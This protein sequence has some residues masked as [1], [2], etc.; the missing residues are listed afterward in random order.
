M[1]ES[2]L[3]KTVR[4]DD[5][6]YNPKGA[7]FEVWTKGRHKYIVHHMDSKGI[8]PSASTEYYIDGDKISASLTDDEVI[9]AWLSHREAVAKFMSDIQVYKVIQDPYSDDEPV[10]KRVYGDGKS[11]YYLNNGCSI[12]I[13]WR[14]QKPNP[15][16]DLGTFSNPEDAEDY[17]RGQDQTDPETIVRRIAI[18]DYYIPSAVYITA[19]SP[20]I[21]HAYMK[22][23]DR[24]V[25]IINNVFS[26]KYSSLEKI[27][28]PNK[29]LKLFWFSQTI[30][31]GRGLEDII[32]AIGH[33]KNENIE[34]SLLGSVTVKSLNYFLI[35]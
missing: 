28:S 8:Q 29:T 12:N 21:A 2:K 7:K 31:K 30:G 35:L 23:Y 33:S 32:R 13:E 9:K 16:F 4:I 6:R 17:Y 10:T 27:S 5:K 26:K 1:A 14:G 34:L 18:E 20:M 25:S 11:P 24:E 22:L 3:G 19:A 15:A